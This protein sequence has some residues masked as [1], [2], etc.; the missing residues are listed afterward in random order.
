MCGANMVKKWSSG[1]DSQTCEFS[2]K[3]CGILQARYSLLYVCLRGLFL[4]FL[5]ELTGYHNVAMG[6][7]EPAKSLMA[8]FHAMLARYP[9]IRPLRIPAA[10]IITSKTGLNP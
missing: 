6:F 3:P 2:P 1:V 8:L 10:K 4:E 5:L 7:A 9:P